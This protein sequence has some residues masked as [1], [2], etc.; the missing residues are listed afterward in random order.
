M[1]AQS[2]DLQQLWQSCAA[3]AQRLRQEL[4]E[5]AATDPSTRALLNALDTAPNLGAALRALARLDDQL[6]QQRAALRAR[7]RRRPGDL[8]EATLIGLIEKKNKALRQLA[9]PRRS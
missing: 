6:E 9:A 4:A 7:G 3:G 8:D 1:P 2:E 5:A